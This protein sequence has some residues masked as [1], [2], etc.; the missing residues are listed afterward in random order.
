MR[1]QGRTLN[2]SRIEVAVLHIFVSTFV[3]VILVT[4]T[5]AARDRSYS[6]VLREQ[7][8]MFAMINTVSNPLSPLSSHHAGFRGVE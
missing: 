3:T 2:K 1:M 5:M 4:G 7:R 8:L 6:F